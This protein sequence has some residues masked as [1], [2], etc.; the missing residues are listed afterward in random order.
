M[1]FNNKWH[2]LY[3]MLVPKNMFPVNAIIYILKANYNFGA[4]LF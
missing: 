3:W 2:K 1:S 4:Y